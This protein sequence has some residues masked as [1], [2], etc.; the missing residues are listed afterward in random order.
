MLI[1]RELNVKLPKSETTFMT[2]H[3][4]NA[5]SNDAQVQ[6]TMQIT[7]LISGIIGIIQFQYN[8]TLDTSSFNYSRFITHLRILLVRLLRKETNQNPKLDPSLLSSM[9]VKY[10]KAYDTAERIATYLHSKMGW[11]LDLDDKF[12]LE[13]HIFRVTS[14]QEK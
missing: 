3:L 5:A 6:E 2:Y 12:Y 8:L 7:N 10:N 13:L 11:T 9:K 1:N 4:V 14:R